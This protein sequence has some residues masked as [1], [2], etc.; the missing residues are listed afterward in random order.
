MT[1]PLINIDSSMY[2]LEESVVSSE[3]IDTYVSMYSLNMLD[4]EKRFEHL[5]E[6]VTSNPRFWQRLVV[7]ADRH[8]WVKS[9]NYGIVV[10]NPNVDCGFTRTY[11]Y[12]GFTEEGNLSSLS[13]NIDWTIIDSERTLISM[14]NTVDASSI[15]KAW[16]DHRLAAN[17]LPTEF[18]E[19]RLDNTDVD[20]A[21]IVTKGDGCVICG[22]HASHQART[23]LSEHSTLMLA[24]NLC[25]EHQLE[26][27]KHPCVLVFFG[28]LFAL[29][30]DLGDLIKLDHIP[31]FLIDPLC[32][33]IASHLQAKCQMAE[34]RK[35]GWHIEFLMSDG[36]Y[37]ILRLN[38]F[39]DYAY[40]L[41]NPK[42]KLM[43][44]I[45][46]AAHHSEVPFGPDHQHFKASGKQKIIT[47]SFS[48]GIPMLDFP[49]LLKSREH[50]SE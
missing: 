14:L 4:V 28:T 50:Y 1:P 36:W 11:R 29:Q 23:T 12:K 18:A 19:G 3:V 24:L 31:D 15:F 7:G 35:R 43:H 27:Q 46:S 47:P 13:S 10:Y 17:A 25:E 48:Y 37:W 21:W 2:A 16:R 42:E 20:R 45:D 32:E 22:K 8:F 33:M 44:K 5:L 41:F 6:L 9:S 40:L 30:I 34:K 39:S 49:L 38:N 26:A